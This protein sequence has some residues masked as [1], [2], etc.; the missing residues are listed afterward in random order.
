MNDPGHTVASGYIRR[1]DRA[2][3]GAAIVKLAIV[4]PGFIMCYANYA[5]KTTVY[6]KSK[7]SEKI[8]LI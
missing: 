2:R 7:K 6:V 8:L 1:Q 4:R 5:I 3:C